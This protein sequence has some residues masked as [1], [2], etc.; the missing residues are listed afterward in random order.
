MENR[1]NELY[2]LID[3]Y[4]YQYYQ[5]NQ[6]EI[7]D[8]EYDQLLLELKKLESENIQYKRV[9]SPTERVGGFVDLK[10]KKEKHKVPMYSLDNVFSV[11][12]F[13]EFDQKIRSEFGGNFS[14]V[15]EAKI[16]GLAI[17]LTYDNKL[18]KAVTRGDGITGENVTH[19]ILT[20]KGIPQSIN[21]ELE[22]RGEIYD[23]LKK[24][25][26]TLIDVFQ[27]TNVVVA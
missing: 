19:N 15:C 25:K 26:H 8:F 24:L 9:N 2:D 14:Y 7:T 5:E 18:I 11:E 21:Q 27:K 6:S 4:N 20:M 13:R 3:K 22:V 12:E 23:E 1:M 17:S 10:F 16:D